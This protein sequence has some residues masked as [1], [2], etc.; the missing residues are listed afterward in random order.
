MRVKVKA[1]C[2]ECQ[3]EFEKT[4]CA[5]NFCSRYCTGIYKNRMCNERWLKDKKP[6][7]RNP[8][9]SSLFA[10]TGS[11]LGYLDSDRRYTAVG[12]S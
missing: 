2:K 7:K 5:D 1:L 6:A 11:Y 3:A 10:T 12:G 4:S 8:N 9:A